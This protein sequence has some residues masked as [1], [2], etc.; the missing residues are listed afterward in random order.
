V[1]KNVWRYRGRI[2]GKVVDRHPDGQ[3]DVLTADG[4]LR[5]ERIT[6]EGKEI[7]P[8]QFIRSVRVTLGFSPHIVFEE[9]EK[10]IEQAPD[11]LLG[12]L[13]KLFF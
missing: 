9:L 10:R 2:P 11:F 8:S 13:S 5:L 1:P 7:I 4:T 3:V 12:K 6:V